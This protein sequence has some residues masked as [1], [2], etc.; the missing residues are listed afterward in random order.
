MLQPILVVFEHERD[1]LS[2]DIKNIIFK[3]LFFP[4]HNAMY[5]YNFT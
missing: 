4:Q 1:L 5:N 2:S 3:D